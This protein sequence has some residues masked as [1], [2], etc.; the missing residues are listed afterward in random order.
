[1]Y[2]RNQNKFFAAL[3]FLVILFLPFH[4][5]TDTVADLKSRISEQSARIEEID[6][7][8]KEYEKQID[9]VGKQANTLSNTVKTLELERQKL[10]ASIQATQG[11]IRATNLTIEKLSSEIGSK[12]D[13]IERNRATIATSLRKISAGEGESFIELLLAHEDLSEFW[14]EVDNITRFQREM[15]NVVDDLEDTKKELESDKS[16]QEKRKND[17]VVLT[18]ELGSKSQIVE[19]NKQE[20]STLLKQTKNQEEGYKKL[21]EE[22]KRQHEELEKELSDLESEL[23]IAVDP[24]ALPKTGQGVLKWPLDK[25]RIT[26]NFG[27]TAFATKNSQIYNGKGHN[28]IDLGIPT[29]TAVK[30]SLTGT[31]VETGNTDAVYGCLS[32]GKWILI[33]HA[34]GLST[35]YAHL[36]VIA[37]S[38]G[39]TVVTGDVIGYS[40]S[41]GYSTGPHLHFTVFATQGMEVVSL[42]NSVRCKNVRIPVADYKAYLNPLSYL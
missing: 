10:L 22:K 41:T 31:I 14:T 15:K 23:R 2:Y 38:A 13:R 17:L 3:F 30:A 12:E 28:G 40:G 36:S 42:V 7:I 32:Y 33:K 37:V 11:K 25:V 24:N 29:G 18:K 27:N 26:Q 6:R 19:A 5:R 34:N 21:L 16:D 9:T 1:M 4:A 8:I 35:L 20:T 39:Q